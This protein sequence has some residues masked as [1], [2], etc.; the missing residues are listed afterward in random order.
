[1][2]GRIFRLDIPAHQAVQ[3]LLP[4]YVSAQLAPEEAARVQ[5]HLHGCEEC[6][7]E[8]E[9]ARRL[10]G[11]EPDPPPGLDVDRALAR[12]MSMLGEQEPAPSAAPMTALSS[13][14]SMSAQAPASPPA[15]LAATE[16]PAPDS[17]SPT[18]APAASPQAAM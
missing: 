13:E 11:L 17:Q 8:A 10:R 6:R 7:H 2:S 4:W 12:M 5:E 18:T 1:M 3:E 15:M 16:S 14:P 9:A